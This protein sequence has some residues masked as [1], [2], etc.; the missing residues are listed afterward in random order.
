MDELEKQSIKYYIDT[1][2]KEVSSLKELIKNKRI[3]K[4]QKEIALK[5]IKYIYE[6]LDMIDMF[7]SP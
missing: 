4:D 7:I 6:L 1:I 5:R 2:K 3:Q